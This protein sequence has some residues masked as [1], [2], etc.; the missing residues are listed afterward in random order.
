VELFAIQEFNKPVKR[1]V[2]VELVE[3]GKLVRCKRPALVFVQLDNKSAGV[4][5][6]LLIYRSSSYNVT[7][8][9][10]HDY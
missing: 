7:T 4:V 6:D 5:V 8:S 3:L 2:E 1:R 9:K 10:Y